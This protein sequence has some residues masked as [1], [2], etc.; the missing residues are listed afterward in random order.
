MVPT[1]SLSHIKVSLY[2]VHCSTAH[3]IYDI[4]KSMPRSR[5][6]A[7]LAEIQERNELPATCNLQSRS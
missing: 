7:P 5:I 6:D 1:N 2:P 4:S 3:S